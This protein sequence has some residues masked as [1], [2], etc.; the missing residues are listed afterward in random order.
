MEKPHP[1][2]LGGISVSQTKPGIHSALLGNHFTLLRSW[3]LFYAFKTLLVQPMGLGCTS[4]EAL[5]CSGGLALPVTYKP[6]MLTGR[7]ALNGSCYRPRGHE[8]EKS[9]WRS[10]STNSWW[11]RLRLDNPKIS[12]FKIAVAHRAINLKL[13]LLFPCSVLL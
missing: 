9:V 11:Q 1:S 4:W 3:K 13:Q 6:L 2:S 10:E 8:L 5:L 7:R 12:G